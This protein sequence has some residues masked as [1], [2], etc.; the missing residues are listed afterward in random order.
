MGMKTR[1]ARLQRAVKA[2]NDWC[3]RHRHEPVKE[4]HAMLKRKLQGHYNYFGVNGNY[5]SLNALEQLAQRI[6][7]KWLCRRS[8]RKRLTWARFG[9]VLEVYPLPQP[10][11]RVQLWAST[12]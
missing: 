7:F 11:I 8:Q 10:R 9:D 1:K 12:S 4:Q 6:W 5:R 3:R 2:V